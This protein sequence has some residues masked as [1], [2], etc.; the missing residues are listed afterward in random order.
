VIGVARAQRPSKTAAPVAATPTSESRFMR[1]AK[2][3]SVIV[4]LVSAA[5]G[6]VFVLFPGV[7]PGQDAPTA[8]QSASVGGM[9]VNPHTTRGQFL[10][11]SDQSK[12]GFTR[13]QLAVVGASAFARVQVVGYRGKT[14][15]FERQ[16]VDATTGDVV[17]QARDFK[18]TP[19]AVKVTHRWWDWTPLRPGT[20]SYVMV[21][22]VLD[23]RGISAIACG[24][25]ELFSGLAGPG[26]AKPLHLCEGS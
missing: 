6:L 25:S 1:I 2:Q 17:G 21:I 8:D 12:L 11:Y 22:K 20:G 10:D 26:S 13:E 19:T 16:I 3:G 5:V 4:G 18:V 9:V 7:R 15:T 23:E 24:Q 14:L